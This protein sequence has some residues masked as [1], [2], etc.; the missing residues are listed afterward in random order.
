MAVAHD[1]YTVRN[2]RIE[3]DG[4]SLLDTIALAELAGLEDGFYGGEKAV[5]VRTHNGIEALTLRFIAGVAGER[6]QIKTDAGDGSLELVGHGVE[7]RILALVA[8]D[9]ANKED[10][11]EHDAGDEDQEKNDPDEVDGKAPAREMDPRNVQVDEQTDQ[12]HAHNDEERCGSAAASK[13][14]RLMKSVEDRG[15]GEEMTKAASN[16]AAFDES[17]WRRLGD[18]GRLGVFGVELGNLDLAGQAKFL[19]CPNAVV[20]DVEL[21]PG[22]AVTSTDWM[23]MMVVMPAFAAG[24]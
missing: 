17:G 5:G 3:F 12:A 24:E 6:V 16:E 8:T 13:V 11:V 23:R 22:E 2:Q 14:H 1:V 15:Y 4:G 21:V 18:A 9:F 7:E 10:G 19:H 20:V